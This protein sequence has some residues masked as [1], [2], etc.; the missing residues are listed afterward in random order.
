[1]IAYHVPVTREFRDSVTYCGLQQMIRCWCNVP[2][3]DTLLRDVTDLIGR[4]VTVTSGSRYHQ[5]MIHFNQELGEGSV[6]TAGS[7]SIVT[8][9]LMVSR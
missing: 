1:M 9:D 2:C 8:E 6:E 5:R 4:R 7:D 3:G